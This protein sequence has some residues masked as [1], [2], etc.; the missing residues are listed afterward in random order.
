MSARYLLDTNICIFMRKELFPAM[1]ER[2]AKLQPG[3]LAM[4]VV[5]WGELVTGAEKSQQ[6]ERTLANLARLREIVPVLDL[7]DDVGDHYG[8]IRGHLEKS[9]Q[10][11][12]HNDNWIAAHARALGLTLITNNTREFAKVSGLTVEDWT[13]A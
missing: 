7:A 12:G 10:P 1:N 4:S 8:E 3:A 11:I 5:T 9:G 2:I 13:Q 6:R